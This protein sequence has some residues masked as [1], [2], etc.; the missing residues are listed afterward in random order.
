MEV[1]QPYVLGW[2]V[3]TVFSALGAAV[4]YL[5]GM[6]RKMRKDADEVAADRREHG[7]HE[8]AEHVWLEH[9]HERPPYARMNVAPQRTG[10]DEL[11]DALGL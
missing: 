5:I 9:F 8:P 10:T 11:T 2:L 3:P 6:V 7:R 4:G 1:L